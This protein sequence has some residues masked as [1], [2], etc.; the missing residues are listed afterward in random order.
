M[1]SPKNV[2]QQKSRHSATLEFPCQ[3]QLNHLGLHYGQGQLAP[4]F[5]P[6]DCPIGRRTKKAAEAAE[7]AGGLGCSRSEAAATAGA[8]AGAH[9]FGCE[10]RSS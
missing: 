8:R 10:T 5:L 3:I 4:I 7:A 2:E 9:E 1:G 6:Y